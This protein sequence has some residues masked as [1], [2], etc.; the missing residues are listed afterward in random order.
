MAIEKAIKMYQ[1]NGGRRV[2][3]VFYSGG[4]GNT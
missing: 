1:I 4:T 2:L 3:P